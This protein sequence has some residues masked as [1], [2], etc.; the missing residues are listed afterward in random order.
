MEPR[1]G[2]FVEQ[3]GP[4]QLVG[5]ACGETVGLGGACIGAGGGGG[6]G[7]GEQAGVVDQL[8]IRT[9]S[10]LRKRPLVSPVFSFLLGKMPGLSGERYPGS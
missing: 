5:V 1:V 4:L 6:F 10:D 8:D 9:M 7:Q 3:G 2:D